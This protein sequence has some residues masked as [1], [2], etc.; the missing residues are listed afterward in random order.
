MKIRELAGAERDIEEALTYY[1]DLSSLYV[2][3]L[4]HEIAVA[5]KAIAQ[6]P[7]A[8]H[9]L[10]GGLR[11]YVLHRYPYSIV[12]QVR[13]NEILI[14]AYAHFKRRPGYWRNR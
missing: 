5:K 4:L 3:D 6:F 14:V 2:E 10:Q 8:W 9:S 7:Q 11:R 12:Y 13:K 1:A